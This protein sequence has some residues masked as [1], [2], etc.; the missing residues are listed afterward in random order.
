MTLLFASCKLNEVMPD[1]KPI[2]NMTLGE[3]VT[4]KNEKI[5]LW[6]DAALTTGFHKLY[7][8][9]SD[10]ANKNVANAS[11]DFQPLMDMGSMKHSSPVEQPIYNSASGLSDPTQKMGGRN[12]CPGEN[13]Q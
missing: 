8:S 6:S 13:D 4:S 3:A 2:E 5:T 11:V 10:A 12:E 7:I 9:V 1:E